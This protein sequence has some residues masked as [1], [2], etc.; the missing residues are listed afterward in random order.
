MK[1]L[2]LLVFSR[3]VE[4]VQSI[5]PAEW[6]VQFCCRGGKCPQSHPLLIYH[7]SS[8]ASQ[9]SKLRK[10]K[11]TSV[12]P[13]GL[14][15]RSSERL[16]FRFGEAVLSTS[17]SWKKSQVAM[18]RPFLMRIPQAFDGRTTF[19]FEV[20]WHS[21]HPSLKGGWTL[22]TTRLPVRVYET[23]TWAGDR[24]CGSDGGYKYR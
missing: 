7:R 4:K 3:G 15:I 20:G 13:R 19:P 17:T 21:D 23:L 9:G 2:N 8:T 10:E 14:A 11:M 22:E 16:G 12:V 6:E 1:T 24:D 5:D 18:V